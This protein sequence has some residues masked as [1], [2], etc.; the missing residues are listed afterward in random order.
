MEVH[1]LIFKTPLTFIVDPRGAPGIGATKQ[2]RFVSHSRETDLWVEIEQ[3]CQ[4]WLKI[5]GC[6]IVQ[7]C[8]RLE[9]STTCVA[10]V[11]ERR[12]GVTIKYYYLASIKRGSNCFEH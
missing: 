10:L 1:R 5:G 4:V 8:D 3:D 6:N 2:I 7:L 12:V 11:S 9:I